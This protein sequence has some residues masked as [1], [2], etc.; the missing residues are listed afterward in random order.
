MS[1]SRGYLWCNLG[2]PVRLGPVDGRVLIFILLAAF[3]WA[4]WTLALAVLASI[5]LAMME[6]AGYSV[7]N[8]F[9]RS[10][11]LIMG[12]WRPAQATRRLRSDV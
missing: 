1:F 5:G 12:K 4:L 8:L 2:L 3:H 10:Q 6:R 11:V 9:R 7:P